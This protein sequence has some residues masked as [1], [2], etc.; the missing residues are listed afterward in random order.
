M[1]KCSKC[2]QEKDHAEFAHVGRLASGE[3]RRGPYCKLCQCA[4]FKSYYRRNKKKY[5]DFATAYRRKI[6]EFIRKSKNG[7]PCADCGKIYP[8]YVMDYD[9]RPGTEKVERLAMMFRTGSLRRVK[10]EIAKCDLVCSN[11]HRVRTFK[12]MGR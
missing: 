3:V 11:C 4:Y 9:H 6:Q 10:E 5:M 1:K 7:K 2:G 8:Y 12:R